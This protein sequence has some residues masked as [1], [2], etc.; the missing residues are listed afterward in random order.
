MNITVTALAV[1]RLYGKAKRRPSFSMMT[2]V[3]AGGPSLFVR[4]HA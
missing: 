4:L 2:F 1:M 3:H